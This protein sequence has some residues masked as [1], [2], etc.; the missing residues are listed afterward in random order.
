[1]GKKKKK[2]PGKKGSQAQKAGQNPDHGTEQ[3][4]KQKAGQNPGHGTEQSSKQKAGQNLEEDSSARHIIRKNKGKASL[5]VVL[6]I[7]VV[8]VMVAQFFNGNYD[9]VF[10]CIL[11]LFLFLIPSF[12]DKRL[13]IELPNTLEIV[14]LLF[15]FAA[16][17]LGEVQQ[18]Y[19]IFDHWDT[20]LHTMNGF[21]M[22]AIGFSLIDI[23]NRS[24]RVSVN[25]SPVFVAMVA[26]CF[27]MTIG[28]LWEFFEF[29][30]D[31]FTHTDM[32][33]DTI[34]HS[35][36]S[37]LLNPNHVNVPVTIPIHSV[38]VNGESWPGY[39]DIGLIDT[40]MDLFV[41][42]IGAVVF[43]VIGVFYIKGRGKGT[44][45]KRFIPKMKSKEAIEED[46]RETEEFFEGIKETEESIV[47]SISHR[48][49]QVCDGAQHRFE[50]EHDK[51]H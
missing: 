40:M 26:F 12:I 51:R 50:G 38:V 31:W 5:Y 1:M 22:A 28:V 15:I 19:L 34:V 7:L 32:Q 47:Q 2:G 42:F 17:I 16:E 45:A 29:G 11:T 18:Y 10:M 21:L 6:R 3:N 44:F 33:K 27:S 25:L 30:M 49:E 20:M 41:N 46:R 23:L 37:V 24:D 4:S 36:S 8:L 13:H 9:N 43:S 48:L 14:I 35:I 39:I